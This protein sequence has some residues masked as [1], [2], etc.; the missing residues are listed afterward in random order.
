M[1][2]EALARRIEGVL[3]LQLGWMDND[4]APP[5]YRQQRIDTAIKAMENMADWQFDQA[6]KI[7]DTI[8]EPAPKRGNGGES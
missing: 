2:G 4:H 1:M 5:S 3:K 8:A 6:I 7:I